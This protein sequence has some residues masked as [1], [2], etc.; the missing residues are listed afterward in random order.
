MRS[1]VAR[2]VNVEGFETEPFVQ[3]SGDQSK[4][5][6]PVEVGQQLAPGIFDRRDELRF[7]DLVDGPRRYGI[8]HFGIVS[9]LI[10]KGE[11]A[12]HVNGER[13]CTDC[14][15]Q[16]AL[17]QGEVLHGRNELT[18]LPLAFVGPVS[19][20]LTNDEATGI[21]DHG[22]LPAKRTQEAHARAT[23]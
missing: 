18:N 17:E 11:D 7:E 20:I 23:H 14:Q 21:Q 12:P 13:R 22:S 5:R 4:Q 16:Q 9:G 15:R 2:G 10:D 6:A 19:T 3:A 8:R 1:V